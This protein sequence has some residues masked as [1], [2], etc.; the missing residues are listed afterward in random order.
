MILLRVQRSLAAAGPKRA[1]HDLVTLPTANTTK[2]IVSHGPP[3]YSAV[4][5]HVVTIFGCTGFLGRYLASKLAKMGTQVIVPYREEEDARIMKPMGDLGQIVRMEWDIR[6]DAQIAECV[7]HSDIVYNLVGRDYET[8][9][10]DFQSVHVA[11]AEKIAA[12]SADCGVP[13]FVHVS[14]LNASVD[15]PSK[16]YQTKAL[17]EER[18]KAV[19]PT[20]TIVRP[21]AMYGF[22][23]KL[24][25]NIAV[26]PWWWK[27]NGGKTQ[28]RPVHVLD[29]AQVLAD[30]M[31]TPQMSRTLSLPGPSTLTY[32]YLLDLVSAVTLR[33]FHSYAPAVPRG[34][35]TTIAK[36]AQNVWWPLISPDEVTRRHLND[37]DVPGDW[38]E[39]GITPTEIEALALTFLRRYRST[40][41]YTD[42][43]AFPTRPAIS[44]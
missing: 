3:G 34:V 14:H 40:D 32:E 4:S 10:F 36:I 5:G 42:P 30:L 11:G 39:L 41:T 12:V 44:V 33:S 35:A 6:N 23:D 8:K 21:G 43:V 24:L 2:P 37:S 7:R 19:F 25:N 13:R 17:G 38:T 31:P 15:S 29:V 22:E 9:N 28:I 16:F 27:L 20:A 18:V 26:S 1:Y